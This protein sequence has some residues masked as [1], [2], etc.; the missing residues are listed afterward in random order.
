MQGLYGKTL[1]AL[2]TPARLSSHLPMETR[3]ILADRQVYRRYIDL[4]DEHR[5]KS[6]CPHGEV[7]TIMNAGYVRTS[8]ALSRKA[9]D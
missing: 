3:S 2:L 5:S 7:C 6:R 9:V 4:A 8:H 1:P